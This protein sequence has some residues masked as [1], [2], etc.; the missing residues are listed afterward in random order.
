MLYKYNSYLMSCQTNA[1]SKTLE[2]HAR[3]GGI[4]LPLQFRARP[5]DVAINSGHAG[6]MT[7][8]LWT[9]EEMVGLLDMFNI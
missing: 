3:A 4:L 9:L 8:H 1:I 5:S 7:D 2:N 6:G